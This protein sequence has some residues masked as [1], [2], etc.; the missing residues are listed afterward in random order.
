MDRS[1]APQK[2]TKK[3]PEKNVAIMEL[4]KSGFICGT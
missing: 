2:V 3:P 4:G 1:K